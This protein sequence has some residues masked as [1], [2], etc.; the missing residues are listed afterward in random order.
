MKNVCG[1]CLADEDL[2]K[3]VAANAD[4]TEC[5]FCDATQDRPFA[6]PLD[7]V[8]D[9]IDSCIG[10]DFVDPVEELPFESREGGYQGT[11]FDSWEILEEIGFS[12]TSQ[13]LLEE[14]QSSFNDRQWC[15]K[16]YFLLTKDERKQYGWD[17]FKEAVK[18]KRR[19]T[20]WSMG[21]EMEDEGHPDSLPVGNMLDEIGADILR[22]KLIKQLSLGSAFWRV[23]VHPTET[24]FTADHELSP[25]PDEYAV[26]SNRM[27]PAGVSMFYG[28]DTFE[29]A[30][31]E[32]IDFA[33]AEG[34]SVTG[35]CFR[36][37]KALSVLDLIDLPE[38]PGFFAL[39]GAEERPH[40]RF[41]RHFV[42]DLAEPIARDGREHV[43]YVPTQVFTEYLRCVLTQPDKSPVHGIRY[44]SSRNHQPCIVIFCRQDECIEDVEF[45]RTERVMEFVSSSLR[46]EPIDSKLQESTKPPPTKSGDLCPGM[47]L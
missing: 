45:R 16:D 25:P 4:S 33:S 2:A 29:T 30:C 31:A 39:E 9:H 37:V 17:R 20:F 11:V 47:R 7:I 32:T 6:A 10:R 15:R 18:H 28:A 12:P 43:E 22:L 26:Q 21:D 35:A 19:F 23:R 8:I 1:D 24:P 34:K 44:R 27:S 41:L 3:V 13:R 14:I 36:T 38:M 46:T 5:D 40:L 42:R